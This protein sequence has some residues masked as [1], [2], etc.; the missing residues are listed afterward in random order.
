MAFMLR[1]EVTRNK[2]LLRCLKN[3]LGL[4]RFFTC[5]FSRSLHVSVS[6]TCVLSLRR[7][8]LVKRCTYLEPSSYCSG[9]SVMRIII[10]IKF[11]T[12]GNFVEITIKPFKRS[13]PYGAWFHQ[14]PQRHDGLK[15][16]G[17][18]MQVRFL[19]PKPR[20]HPS[21]IGQKHNS[22]PDYQANQREPLPGTCCQNS[23]FKTRNYVD[24]YCEFYGDYAHS[25]CACACAA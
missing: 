20:P 8:L 16:P 24:L 17:Y 22:M 1:L 9:T 14:M 11:F 6:F 3:P 19:L 13:Q 21:R 5:H 23:G 25:A 4:L 10:S 7:I 18:T 12:I 2:K 15:H